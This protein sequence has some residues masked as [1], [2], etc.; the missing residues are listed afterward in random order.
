MK[1]TAIQE[2]FGREI[3]CE[4]GDAISDL[5]LQELIEMIKTAGVLLFRNFNIDLE[6]FNS[7]TDQFGTDYD[8]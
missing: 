1:V 5:K 3:K 6:R 2:D 7:F 4:E 8:V